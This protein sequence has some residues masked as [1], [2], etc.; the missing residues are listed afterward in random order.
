METSCRE[1]HLRKAS[2]SVILSLGQIN[3][4]QS[5]AACTGGEPI[6]LKSVGKASATMP[7][8]RK[9]QFGK[10]RCFD[11]SLRAGSRP[12]GECTSVFLGL[13]LGRFVSVG[14]DT[15]TNTP[16][17]SI[18]QHSSGCITYIANAQLRNHTDNQK[19]TKNTALY[20]FCT[21]DLP[22]HASVRNTS[23]FSVKTPA[24]VFF[25]S[26]SSSSS[27]SSC[28]LLWLDSGL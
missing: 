19:N 22:V 28:A 20:F 8:S 5:L 10:H 4:L 2:Y 13:C 3:S 27:S 25:N 12:H 16:T 17:M 26:S 14:Q 23:A 24:K 18:M 21:P 9:Q 11:C 15:R 7:A 1:V 6:L